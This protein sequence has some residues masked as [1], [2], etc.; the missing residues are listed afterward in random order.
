MRKQD[1]TKTKKNNQISPIRDSENRMII[2]R[3]LSNYNF[4]KKLQGKDESQ[5]RA[6][7]ITKAKQKNLKLKK[8]NLKIFKKKNL[9]LKNTTELMN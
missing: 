4:S 8:I 7:N 2:H 1:M 5:Q 9:K 6:R 3:L